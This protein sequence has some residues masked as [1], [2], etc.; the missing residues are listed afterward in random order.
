MARYSVVLPEG[1]VFLTFWP[2][3]RKLRENFLCDL[4][5]SSEAGGESM[6]NDL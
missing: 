6:S 5:D 3:S 4:C 2:L 1:R